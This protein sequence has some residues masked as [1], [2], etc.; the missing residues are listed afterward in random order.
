MS[1]L[2]IAAFRQNLA[3]PVAPA[4]HRRSIDRQAMLKERLATE[5]LE[6]WQNL[7]DAA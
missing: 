5:M 6:L 7:G 3:D 1:Q 4:G 2:E